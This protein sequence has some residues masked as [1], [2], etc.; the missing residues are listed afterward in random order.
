MPRR[1]ED[2]SR[3]T[4]N[5]GVPVPDERTQDDP[6]EHEPPPPDRPRQGRVVD[7]V[8]Q[9]ARLIVASGELALRHA[10]APLRRPSSRHRETV[11]YMA[12]II[13][14]AVLLGAFLLF[15]LPHGLPALPA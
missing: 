8:A 14:A 15:V 12:A 1:P 13:A 4:P 7:A 9:E 5:T 10:A 11:S 2:V 6:V 3:N